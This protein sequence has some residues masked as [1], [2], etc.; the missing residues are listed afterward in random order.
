MV[1]TLKIIFNI[2]VYLDEEGPFVQIAFLNI[3]KDS[4]IVAK[5]DSTNTD[6]DKRAFSYALSILKRSW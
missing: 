4:H 2:N 1:D 6:F 5:A 3:L